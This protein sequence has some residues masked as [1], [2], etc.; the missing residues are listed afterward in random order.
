MANFSMGMILLGWGLKSLLGEDLVVTFPALN[1]QLLA[2]VFIAIAPGVVWHRLSLITPAHK[3]IWAV[4]R[5]VGRTA[6]TDDK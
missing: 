2:W 4:G 5:W 3:T 6:K 1:N